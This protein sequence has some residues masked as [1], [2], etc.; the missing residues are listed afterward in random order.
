[1]RPAALA[2][3]TAFLALIPVWSLSPFTGA[4][5]LS[6]D[7]IVERTNRVAYYQGRDGRARVQMTITD[8]QGRTRTRAFT[9]LRR[10]EELEG[11][12]PDQATGEQRMYIYFRRPA[13]VNKMVFIVWKHPGKDDD[14]WL[15][16]PA[17]D[18]V[19]RIAATD[20]RT[21]FVG[22][23]FLYEDV[24]G[25][26]PE[27]DDHDLVKTT[28]T[29]YVLRNRPKNPD[30][31]E[32]DHYDMWIH[33]ETFIP[34]RTEYFKAS[35]ERYRLYEALEVKSIDGYHTVIRARMSDFR[36][37]GSTLLEYG[38]LGYNLD[39]PEEVFTE[40]YLRSPPRR[41]LR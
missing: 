18:L 41:Y 39:L 35:G 36:S 11:A 14:R 19:K 27:E 13:D 12:P 33:R 28:D 7:Q 24:S 22:S 21:S 38:S 29:Y 15:Y 1:M 40:R 37:G 16:L 6:V 32:F 8:E 20:K 10:D 4:E 2:I 30:S 25:R 26:S 17:L 5:E 3:R 34:V 23:H 9:I 31:V